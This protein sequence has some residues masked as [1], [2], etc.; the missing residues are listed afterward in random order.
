MPKVS[1]HNIG[2]GTDRGA[3]ENPDATAG[4]G[5][6]MA[7]EPDHRCPI[8]LDTM[9]DASYAMP[10]LHRFCFGCILPKVS[11]HSYLLHIDPI[12]TW[13]TQAKLVHCTCAEVSGL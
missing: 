1:R 6:L 5:V 4:I 8:C 11:L 7:S 10:C 9:D 12:D 3:A 2:N 13:V